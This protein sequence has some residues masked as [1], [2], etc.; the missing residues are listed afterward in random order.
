VGA[1]PIERVDRILPAVE[2]HAA[3]RSARNLLGHV[4]VHGTI[5]PVADARAILGLSRRP[6][7]LTDHLVLVTTVDG[8]VIVPVDEAIGVGAVF[9]DAAGATG[10]LRPVKA[11]Q[12]AE[13]VVTL[14][15]PDR[16]FGSITQRSLD[17]DAVP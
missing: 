16:V 4:N 14:I 17:A 3:S 1:L 2:I 10:S 5:V 12:L 8:P 15:D 7:S 6:L 13:P 11:E 9:D